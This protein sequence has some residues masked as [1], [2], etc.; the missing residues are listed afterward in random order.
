NENDK[1]L[2]Y[3][4][5]YNSNTNNYR[6]SDLVSRCAGNIMLVDDDVLVGVDRYGMFYALAL[7]QGKTI[8]RISHLH[9][10]EVK[11]KLVTSACYN[12]GETA[13]RIKKRPITPSNKI[14]K[15]KNDSE[16]ITFF[17]H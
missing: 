10:Q 15:L 6:N 14:G 9:I 8:I 1:K 17:L 2:E 12:I 4:Q 3:V 7:V 11:R 16:G 13:L 5:R